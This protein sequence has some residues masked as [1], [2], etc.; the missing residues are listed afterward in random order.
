MRM[1]FHPMHARIPSPYSPLDETCRSIHILA[2]YVSS[3]RRAAKEHSHRGDVTILVSE[4]H[5][6]QRRIH[7]VATNS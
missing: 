2:D 6:S 4:E 1:S 7:E 5:F 3:L